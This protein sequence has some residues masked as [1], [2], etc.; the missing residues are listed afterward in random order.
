MRLWVEDFTSCLGWALRVVGVALGLV[1]WASVLGSE[2][3]LTADQKTAAVVLSATLGVI[4]V[5]L[6]FV[7]LPPSANVTRVVR[8]FER[9]VVAAAREVAGGDGQQMRDLTPRIA[10]LA[11]LSIARTGR[12][13]RDRK[14]W[15]RT[16]GRLASNQVNG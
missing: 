7:H 8:S 16:L 15:L 14:T 1:A 4:V 13:P 9:D 2:G 5:Q 6:F 12:V 11:A 10:L 3:Q